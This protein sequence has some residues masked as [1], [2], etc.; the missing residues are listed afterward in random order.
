[1]KSAPRFAIVLV[2]TALAWIEPPASARVGGAPVLNPYVIWSPAA[3]PSRQ[4]R[5]AAA[6]DGAVFMSWFERRDSTRYALRVARFVRG[7][8]SEPATVAEGDS[9]FVNWAD[10]PVLLATGGNRVVIAWPWKHGGEPYAYDVRIAGSGDGGRTWSRPIVPHRDGTATEHGF[11]SL[12]PAQAG[13]VRAFWLD[14]RK[15]ADRPTG[16][17]KDST[18]H[19]EHGDGEMTLRTAWV[20]LDGSLMDEQEVD[21]RVCDCCQTGAVG[22]GGHALV[23]Y[24]DR[25]SEEVRDISVAWLRGGRWS[26][27]APVHRDAWRTPGCPVNGPALD[28]VGSQVAMAWFTM[29]GDSARVLAAVSNDAGRRF[30][31]PVRVDQGDPLGRTDVEMLPDGSALIS[32]LE[33]RGKEALIQVRRLDP[34]GSLSDAATL[35]SASTSRAS[36]FPSMAR[37]QSHL[38]VAWTE[39]GDTSRVRVA[40]ARIP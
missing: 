32:W 7:S 6:P 21:D 40:T 38:F 39:T 22:R 34:R 35:G 24:R 5:L 28:M 19:D 23:A 13:G 11:V 37:S 27:P 25:S 20:G 15:F 2:A 4:P 12:V 26:E 36:G 29:A 10:F 30:G 17:A 14:G 31:A 16:A 33:V 3:P 9:F 8:W 18:A 1:M